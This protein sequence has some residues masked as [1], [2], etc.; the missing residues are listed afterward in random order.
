MIKDPTCFKNSDKPSCINLNNDLLLTNF[1]KS[2][3]KSQTLETGL[4]GFHKLALTVLKVYSEKERTIKIFQMKFFVQ[5]FC[6]IGSYKKYPFA[7]LHSKFLY[8]LGKHVLIKKRYIR[9]N[10]KNFMEKNL[11]KQSW[12]DLSFIIYL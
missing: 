6:K 9:A 1:P 7:D 4:S 2:F 11:T 3:V 8:A 5:I 12:L 10:L